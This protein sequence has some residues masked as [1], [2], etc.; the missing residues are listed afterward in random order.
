MAIPFVL[1]TAN[2]T[3]TPRH[4]ADILLAD[5]V[6]V[7]LNPLDPDE[8]R[9]LQ[10]Y[11][12]GENFPAAVTRFFETTGRG[13]SNILDLVTSLVEGVGGGAKA[14]APYANY[15]LAAGVLGVGLYYGSKVYK[16]LKAE[17]A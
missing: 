13:T 11:D 14:A 16:N 6:A 4:L 10:R 17:R 8:Q 5:Y 12:A 1:Y 3:P 7:N 15:I 9:A 2:Q